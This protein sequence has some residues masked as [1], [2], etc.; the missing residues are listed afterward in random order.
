MVHKTIMNATRAILLTSKLNDTFWS[1]AVLD[2]TFEYNWLPHRITNQI[3]AMLWHAT[4]R[5]P[6]NFF[7]FGQ[8]CTRPI[9]APKKKLD[10]RAT[11]VQYLHGVDTVSYTHL[12]L[13]TI[14]LV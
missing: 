10:P 11:L 2:A 13:P 6:D 9:H 14:L 7:K 12:T 1:D 4:T 3:P 5:I 8:L